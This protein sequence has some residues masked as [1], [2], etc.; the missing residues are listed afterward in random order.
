M[1]VRAVIEMR[2]VKPKRGKR[3][4]VGLRFGLLRVNKWPA[5]KKRQSAAAKKRAD[6]PFSRAENSGTKIR[7]IKKTTRK[8]DAEARTAKPRAWPSSF[9]RLLSFNS[10]LLMIRSS[11]L[12]IAR[13]W[14]LVVRRPWRL[15]VP[16]PSQ[17]IPRSLRV[18]HDS[19]PYS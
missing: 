17:L 8:S 13:S 1:R 4:M 18:A 14:R 19:L 9:R 7:L 15:V 11:Q 3:G 2:P 10:P 5:R 16:Q 6:L 12:I